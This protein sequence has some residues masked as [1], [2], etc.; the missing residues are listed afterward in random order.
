MYIIY[1]IILHMHPIAEFLELGRKVEAVTMVNNN[2]EKVELELDA[3]ETIWQLF[4]RRLRQKAISEKTKLPVLLVRA[5][6]LGRY[7][8][9]GDKAVVDVPTMPMREG[10]V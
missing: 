3:I 9:E 1:L 7:S 6:L 4:H 2:T 5:V 8:L 10:K